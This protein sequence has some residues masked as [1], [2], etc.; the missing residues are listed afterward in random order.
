M[1]DA[2]AAYDMTVGNQTLFQANPNWYDARYQALVDANRRAG[3][4][5]FAD[6]GLQHRTPQKVRFKDGAEDEDGL[7]VNDPTAGPENKPMPTSV[8]FFPAPIGRRT[9]ERDARASSLTQLNGT[10]EYH[11]LVPEKKAERRR[12]LREELMGPAEKYVESLGDIGHPDEISDEQALKNERFAWPVRA[13]MMRMEKM[14]RYVEMGRHEKTAMNLAYQAQRDETDPLDSDEFRDHFLR[15]Q[16][17]GQ[18]DRDL[19]E[20][21]ENHRAQRFMRRTDTTKLGSDMKMAAGD[22]MRSLGVDIDPNVDLAEQVPRLPRNFFDYHLKQ[23][24]LVAR[25]AANDGG[26][27]GALIEEEDP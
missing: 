27:G 8:R 9:F 22:I 20:E 26:G 7:P 12:A 6:R 24:E 1:K 19:E 21:K 16:I 25:E 2:H 11:K 14:N 3:A 10:P 17:G 23:G 5:F 13:R 15:A 18:A 4:A